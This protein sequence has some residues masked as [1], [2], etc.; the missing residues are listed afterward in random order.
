MVSCHSTTRAEAPVPVRTVRVGSAAD[1]AGSRF[2]GSL[3]PNSQVDLAFKSGGYVEEILQVKGV[4]GN[5]RN[6]QEGDLVKKGTVL[7]QVRESEYRDQSTEAQAS[8]NKA[9][10]DFQ[11]AAQLY[12]NGSVSKADYDAAF[13]AM[14]STKA[15]YAQTQTALHDTK[16]V[17]PMDGVILKRTIEVG[18]LASP[19]TPAIT[20]ADTRTMKVDFGVPDA[21]VGKMKLGTPQV[22]TVTAAPHPEVQGQVSRIAASADPTSR[23][24]NV[25]VTVPNTDSALKAGM[26]ASLKVEIAAALPLSTL[27][28]PIEAVVRPRGDSKGFGVYV[29]EHK[30][31]KAYA[32][33]RRITPGDILGN[34]IAVSEGIGPGDEIITAGNTLVQDGQEVRVVP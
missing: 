26:I 28:V 12:E 3:R 32:H 29:V 31:D 20:L 8:L 14:N 4:D 25:E 2:T 9:K 10:A 19:S 18:Q 22:V 7:A 27:Q 23:D 6:L 34:D 16:I 13:A 33:I 24:F 5:M 15:R 11:R 1:E 21:L 17:A 30:G